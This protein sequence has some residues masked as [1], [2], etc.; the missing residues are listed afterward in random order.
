M[1][2]VMMIMKK[3]EKPK[4]VIRVF[5]MNLARILEVFCCLNLSLNK[6][7]DSSQTEYLSVV[8]WEK[9]CI[10][11]KQRT[12]ETHL[13]MY[14]IRHW[15]FWF[16][17]K[18]KVNYG[19]YVPGGKTICITTQQLF[20]HKSGNFSCFQAKLITPHHFR[21]HLSFLYILYKCP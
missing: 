12:K 1:M 8:G 21:L 18:L 17:F 6:E 5:C 15:Y 4:R 11:L 7:G 16:V 9:V 19:K 14:L 20:D 10:A 13:E 3:T 2:I